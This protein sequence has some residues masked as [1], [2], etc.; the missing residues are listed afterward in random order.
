MS[1]PPAGG[2]PAP[3]SEPPVVVPDRLPTVELA[4]IAFLAVWNIAINTVVPPA[5][6]VP[7]NLAAAVITVILG[8]RGGAGWQ[9]LGLAGSN[10]RRGLR[11]GAMSA[12]IVGITVTAMALIPA[13]RTFL[14]DDR[15]SDVSTSE[16]LYDTLFRIP[17]ATA[18]AEEMAFRGVLLGLL[19]AWMAPLRAVLVSSA[20][21]GLWHILPA[22]AALETSD[23]ISGASSQVVAGTVVGQI[24]LTAATG[25]AFCWL[26][27]R[28]AHVAAPILAHW[29]LNATAYM[30]GWLIVRN[31][32]I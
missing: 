9:E 5:A 31:G 10:L 19:L 7:V 22:M 29:A 24:L 12:T 13:A 28:A 25:V 15:F 18:A 6:L 14:A 3:W 32:W 27:L 4:V 30:A 8:R 16:M 20:L 2:G 23:A 17:L 21:F 1:T 11:L 26:R